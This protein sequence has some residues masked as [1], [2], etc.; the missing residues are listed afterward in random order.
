MQVKLEDC[1][2]IIYSSLKYYNKTSIE[3]NSVLINGFL[4]MYIKMYDIYVRK[5]YHAVFLKINDLDKFLE[6]INKNVK[7]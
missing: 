5:D 1:P 6:F 3:N 7:K 2:I 4:Y